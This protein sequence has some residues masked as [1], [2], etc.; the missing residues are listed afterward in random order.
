MAKLSLNLPDRMIQALEAD[1]EALAVSL[2]ALLTADLIRYRAL[3]DAAV[4][5][6]TD[7]QWDCL[8]HVMSGIEGSRILGGLDDLPSGTS[9][10]IAIDEWADGLNDN[11]GDIS[12]AGM[13]RKQAVEWP[14]LTIA[15]V[16]M[17]LRRR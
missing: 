6:L 4:P 5:R 9:I 10:A 17:R 15:G 3:A 2:P 14:P 12:R 11:D 7:W 13:L 16:L 8:S 1:A